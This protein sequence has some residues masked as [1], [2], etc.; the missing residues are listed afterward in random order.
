M[1][2]VLNYLQTLQLLV[3]I[4]SDEKKGALPLGPM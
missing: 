3:E 1:R 2:A 4:K